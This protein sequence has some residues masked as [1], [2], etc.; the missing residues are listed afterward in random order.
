M[1]K[2]SPAQVAY[3]QAKTAYDAARAEYLRRCAELPPLSRDC[4]DAELE[5]E[6]KA[7]C[8][9]DAELGYGE[10]MTLLSEAETNLINWARETVQALPQY[11]AHAAALAPLWEKW[12]RLPK[13]REKLINLS[14]RLDGASCQRE[15][16]RH[17]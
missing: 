11:A 12:R 9:I 14:F 7:T 8:A 1:P 2:L 3:Q 6:H 4:T 17:G 5:A 10:F 13:I 16:A 15:V